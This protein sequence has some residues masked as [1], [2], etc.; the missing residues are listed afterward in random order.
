MEYKFV[1]SMHFWTHSL[2]P[3]MEPA[4]PEIA[5]I[6]NILPFEKYIQAMSKSY[7]HHIQRL[8]FIIKIKHIP[9][10]S[11]KK[12]K[13]YRKI[14]T[15]FSCS[16]EMTTQRNKKS[17]TKLRNQQFLLQSVKNGLVT[18]SHQVRTEHDRS[19]RARKKKL[20]ILL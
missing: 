17:N 18:V 15:F 8:L 7:N 1:H 14:F 13:L 19:L 12:Y 6:Y 4:E 3:T 11:I 2:N 9:F 20:K 5:Q 10:W 16:Y